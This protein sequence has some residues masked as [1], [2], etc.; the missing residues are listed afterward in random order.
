MQNAKQ[1]LVYL[2]RSSLQGKLV[3]CLNAAAAGTGTYGRT[4]QVLVTPILINWA[5]E[6]DFDEM[7]LDSTASRSR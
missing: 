5:Q 1:S 4:I 7:R 3:V 2:C 6:V